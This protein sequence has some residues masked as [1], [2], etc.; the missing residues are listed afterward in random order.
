MSA[1]AMEVDNL[2]KVFG[3][4]AGRIPGSAE[5]ALPRAE[6]RARTGG[7]AAVRDVSFTVGA[8]EVFVVMGLSG[9]GI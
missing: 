8:G 1:A 9:S 2:W 3:P 7:T 6:L 4:R 5:G